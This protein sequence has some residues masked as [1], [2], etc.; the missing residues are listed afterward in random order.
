METDAQA[1]PGVLFQRP[2]AHGLAGLGPAQVQCP[3]ARRSGSEQ[4]I[5]ADDAVHFGTGEVE[6]ISQGGHRLRRYVAEF[7]LDGVKR[8]Q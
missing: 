3:A 7:V 1:L 4:V 2:R 6:Y 5:E 8:R